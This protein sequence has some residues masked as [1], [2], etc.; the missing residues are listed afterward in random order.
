[1]VAGS[2]F[3]SIDAAIPLYDVQVQ[4]EDPVFRQDQ[5]CQIGE[6][7]F[8]ALSDDRTV[9]GHKQVLGELLGNGASTSPG[10]SPF[11]VVFHRLSDGLPIEAIVLEKAPV[12]GSYSGVL[13]V[14]RDVVS[15]NGL[16]KLVVWLV[17]KE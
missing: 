14:I 5:F 7:D 6:G 3:G 1:M 12:L 15:R 11:L 2:G 17:F 16:I 8:N 13:E 10:S 4:N 9:R